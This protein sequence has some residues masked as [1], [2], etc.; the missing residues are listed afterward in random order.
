LV[1]VYRGLP[2]NVISESTAEDVAA[3]GIP[4]ES[5]SLTHCGVNRSV[6]AYDP[7]GPRYDQPT[8]LYLGRVKKYKSIQH[9]IRAF[10]LV[11]RQVP[12]ARLMVVGTG[13][14][15]DDLKALARSLN[16]TADVEFPGFVSTAD[17]V[18]RMRRAHVAVLPS[19]KEGWGLTNI[20][21]NAVGTPVIA[22]DVP[23]LRDSVQ[24]GR[25]GFLYAHGNI[26]QL[27]K[28]IVRIL[29]DEDLRQELRKGAL[30]WAERF[31]WDRAA[32][33]FEKL[34]LDIVGDRK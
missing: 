22:A 21:A 7:S 15:L 32:R 16:L 9:L 6:Y 8:I 1:A 31:N 28:K 26:E 27:A 14:Y 25:T 29:T 17:K 30:E 18:E 24:D 10:A 23:G 11:K 34:L 3:R 12:P 2:Y 4:R 20:E 5:I 33:E 19:L 13:D